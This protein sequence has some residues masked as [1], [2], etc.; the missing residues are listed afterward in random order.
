MSYKYLLFDSDRTLLDF[1]KSMRSAIRNT[2]TKYGFDVTDE[3]IDFYDAWNNSLWQQFERGEITKADLVYTR[4]VVMCTRY[5]IPYPGK[6]KIET[7]YIVELG[8]GHDLLPNALDVVKTLSEDHK[9]Y[10][11][12]NGFIDVQTPRFE[13]SG[14]KPYIT[15]IFIS[16]QIG[17]EKPSV[18]FFDEVLKRIGNPDK[19]E[20]LV[21]GDSM[22]A[23][24]QGGYLSGI[25][26]VLISKKVPE[27]F[28]YS[29]TYTIPEIKDLL[30]ILKGGN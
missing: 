15:D 2:L 28:D 18:Q 6:G 20:I 19:K 16:E 23:D 24:I 8:K 22:T 29:P 12:T 4:F 27:G 1:D 5:G 17:A 9:C 30:G 21:I 10:I 3:V 14:L 7:D 11:I 13:K 25:D 26:T